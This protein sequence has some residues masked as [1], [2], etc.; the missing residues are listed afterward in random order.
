LRPLRPDRPEPVEGCGQMFPSSV[1]G[2]DESRPYYVTFVRFVVNAL[3]L[4]LLAVKPFDEAARFDLAQQAA[5]DEFF[6]VD[7]AHTGIRF[8]DLS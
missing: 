5:I 6:R 3:S 7:G 1:R 4:S 8:R 2:R